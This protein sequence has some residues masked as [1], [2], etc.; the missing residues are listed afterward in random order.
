MVQKCFHVNNNAVHP[1]NSRWLVQSLSPYTPSLTL[2]NRINGQ[3]RKINIALWIFP[4]STKYSKTYDYF[5]SPGTLLYVKR[6]KKKKSLS[7]M[8]RVTW[9]LMYERPG[10]SESLTN[11]TVRLGLLYCTCVLCPSVDG[12]SLY[13]TDNITWRDLWGI[14]RKKIVWNSFQSVLEILKEM[15]SHDSSDIQIHTHVSIYQCIHV[16]IYI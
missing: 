2:V 16:W 4:C 1:C 14:W 15:Y 11:G 9:W 8:E 13:S 7:L 6:N 5:L 12:S 3:T 10:D